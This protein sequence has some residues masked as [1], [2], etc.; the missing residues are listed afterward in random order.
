MPVP[1]RAQKSEEVQFETFD[2]VELR[3]TFY[4]STKPKAPCV[5]LLHKIGGNR[6]Q[7]GWDNLAQELQKEFAV[8][9]FDF[10]GHGDS[11]GVGPE[12][13][14]NQSNFLIKGA[15]RSQKISFKDFPPAYYPMLANDVAAA[16]RYLDKQ[17]DALAC[18][19]SNVV[20]IGAEEGA[21]IGALWIAS[22]WQRRRFVKSFGGWTLDPKGRVEGE[23][24]AAAVWLS[25][26]KTFAGAYVGRWLTGPFNRV[27]DKTP[28]VFF[29]G[30]KDA[31]QAEAS[32]DLF[33]YVKRAGREKLEFTRLRGK[34]TKLAGSELLDKKSLGTS[35]EIA[36]YLD[37]VMQKRGL[38]APVMRDTENGPPLYPVPLTAFGFALR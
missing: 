35:D 25:I 17:N 38:R 16:K 30:E 7:N 13:W 8:L 28:M 27:R 32:K 3:G 11:T 29:Y 2:K 19:S 24:I 9:S 14:R 37:K 15:G 33:E 21:A 20:V 31:K 4:A 26:P 5:I 12:F 36:T 22:E 34:D 6:Q 23:D 10:R 1:A 18:N